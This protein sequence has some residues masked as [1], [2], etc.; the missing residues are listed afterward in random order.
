MKRALKTEKVSCTMLQPGF[1]SFS[2]ESEDEKH[3]VLDSGPWSF[4]SNLLVLQQCDPDI[5]EMCYNFDH[6][7]FWVN[8]YGLPFGRVT[9]ESC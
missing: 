6:C 3:K 2:F 1:F 8:L 9:K 5:P 7:P 4:A